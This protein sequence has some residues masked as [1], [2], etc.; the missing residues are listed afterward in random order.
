M[1]PINITRGGVG[2]R[3]VINHHVYHVAACTRLL[4]YIRPCRLTFNIIT[5][6]RSTRGLPYKGRLLHIFRRFVTSKSPS[7]LN[8]TSTMFSVISTRRSYHLPNSTLIIQLLANTPSLSRTT[9]TVKASGPAF[10]RI[11]NA[12]SVQNIRITSTQQIT[13]RRN[14]PGSFIGVIIRGIRFFPHRVKP[15]REPRPVLIQRT[16]SR[17]AIRRVIHQNSAQA[18]GCKAR[19]IANRKGTTEAPP[20]NGQLANKLE[21]TIRV[22]TSQSSKLIMSLPYPRNMSTTF[23]VLR[24]RCQVN[25]TRRRTI[26]NRIHLPLFDPPAVSTSCPVLSTLKLMCTTR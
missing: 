20:P 6:S 14:L 1:V 8:T 19:T 9:S 26:R 2:R 16:R 15:I 21:F 23:R 12:N 13:G 5:T 4:A 3:G 7:T 17:K 11:A 10:Q 25:A 18:N 24:L 22:R